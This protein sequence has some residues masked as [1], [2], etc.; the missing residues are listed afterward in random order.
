MGGHVTVYFRR[1]AAVS[2]VAGP[3][4]NTCE[5]RL[6]RLVVN[7]LL[8]AVGVSGRTVFQVYGTRTKQGAVSVSRNTPP[9][10]V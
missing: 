7:T 6:S 10:S 4:T 3:G 1:G 9:K 8:L 2:W 5:M